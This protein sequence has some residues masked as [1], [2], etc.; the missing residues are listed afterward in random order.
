LHRAPSNPYTVRVFSLEGQPF[1]NYTFTFPQHD[2][3]HVPVG[4]RALSALELPRK[5]PNVGDVGGASGSGEP[6]FGR[7]APSDQRP[8]DLEQ[9]GVGDRQRLYHGPVI[10]LHLGHAIGHRN[11]LCHRPR[12]RAYNAIKDS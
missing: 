11:D 6:F 7:S 2:P 12:P 9:D 5:D 10:A 3:Q 1:S 8:D 4:E